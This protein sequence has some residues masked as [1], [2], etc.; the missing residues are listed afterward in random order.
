MKLF[1]LI[2]DQCDQVSSDSRRDDRGLQYRLSKS[3]CF[4]EVKNA[5]EDL[6]MVLCENRFSNFA[7]A[8]RNFHYLFNLNSLI[9]RF[10][11]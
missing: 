10:A 2:G 8:E 9:I 7:S 4:F 6:L 5:P 11:H 3:N 1:L